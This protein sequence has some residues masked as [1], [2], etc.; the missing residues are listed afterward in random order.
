ME[1]DTA[2]Y[3]SYIIWYSFGLFVTCTIVI[4]VIKTMQ[5]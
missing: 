3:V 2:I 4:N 1:L 5:R